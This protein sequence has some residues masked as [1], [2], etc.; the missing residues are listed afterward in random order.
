MRFA[1]LKETWAR[2][3]E[4][5]ASGL[6]F[7]SKQSNY[8]RH[9]HASES[10]WQVFVIEVV[11]KLLVLGPRVYFTGAGYRW[12]IGWPKLLEAKYRESFCGDQVISY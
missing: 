3:C 5:D 12:N 9:L 8:V 11:V 4:R 2:L 6:D 7:P 10:Y 1:T